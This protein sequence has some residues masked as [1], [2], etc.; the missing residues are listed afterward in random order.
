MPAVLPLG[1]RLP[2]CVLTLFL[3]ASAWCQ[4]PTVS[5][6]GTDGLSHSTVQV[7]YSW[8][9]GPLTSSALV[10][11]VYPASCANG[12]RQPASAPNYYSPWSMVLAGLKPATSYNVCVS[13]SNN[14]GTTMSDPVVVTTSALP[15]VH[16]ALPIPP[17][18]FDSDYPDTSGYRN[19]TTAPDCSDLQ[20]NID[21][22]LYEQ[23]DHGTIINIPAGSVCT[24]L[25]RVTF[26]VL[27]KDTKRFWMDSIHPGSPGT[28]T[29]PNHGLT[30]GQ[31]ITFGKIYAGEFPTSRSCQFGNGLVSGSRYYTHVVDSNTIGVYCGDGRTLLSFVDQG[32]AVYGMWLIPHF[33]T[34]GTC[35]TLSGEG[36]CTYWKRSL[37]WIIIRSNAPDKELPPE[38]TRLTPAWCNS[39]KCATLVNP[40]ENTNVNSTDRWFITHNDVDGNANTGV[41]NIHWGPGIELT[42]AIDSNYG[43]YGNLINSFPWSSDIVLDRV[44]L[45]G[46]GTPQRWGGLGLPAFQW[47]GLNFAFK[48]S[49]IDNLTNWGSGA[50]E[51]SSGILPCGPGPTTIVNNYLEGVGIL[52]HFSDEGGSYFLRGD[53][54]VL[55]NTFKLLTRHMY[56]APDSDGYTYGNRQPLEFKA[57][58][59][60]WIGGNTFDTSWNEI[61]GAS[62][63]IAL[64]SVSGEG[65][66]DTEVDSNTFVHGPGLSNIPLIVAGGAPQT[67]P[68][69]RFRFHNNSASDIN[70][71]WWVPVGGSASPTGWVFEGPDGGE[72]VTIDHNTITGNTGR[73]PSIFFLFDTNAEGMNVTNNVFQVQSGNGI[74]VDGSILHPCSN[75]ADAALWECTMSTGS[76]WADNLLIPSDGNVDQLQVAYRGLPSFY[77]PSYSDITSSTTNGK[78]VGVN[79]NEQQIAQGVV[80][81]NGAVP[82]STSATVNFIAPDA[83]GCPVDY[84]LDSSVMGEITRVADS[85]GSRERSIRIDGVEPNK[86]YYF[87]V[88]CATQQPMGSFKTLTKTTTAPSI[89]IV[90]PTGGNLLGTVTLTAN[91]AST[92]GIASVQFQLDGLNLGSAITGSGPT[93]SMSWNT[94]SASNG[95]HTLTAIATDTLGQKTTSSGVKV[96]HVGR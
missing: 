83:Q 45:H 40:V 44:Y 50:H 11:A 63:F 38:H 37:Y 12:L 23:A 14:S 46:Q 8:S 26:S 76:M 67:I 81:L 31:L 1:P 68:P 64:I 3:S 58:Y 78:D 47:S 34:D 41:G 72:D 9:N 88:N 19:V 56:G 69:N 16:P 57:G 35:P 59:R 43:L 74:A 82:D 25:R 54:S 15:D 53:N 52:L 42:N 32:S 94:A 87:R 22:A 89:N 39:G 28:I 51:G 21:Q 5:I 96:Q 2:L 48:D 33:K 91:A 79:L 27:A 13:L 92:A 60:N 18:S 65:I 61:T 75:L 73:I 77:A 10:Y 49:Y 90:S 86:I 66:T 36:P 95:T 6:T 29:I 70:A 20:N 84:A 80:T 62:V 4:L 17:D 93:F 71:R 30:E 7:T 24:A 85:G 55:R